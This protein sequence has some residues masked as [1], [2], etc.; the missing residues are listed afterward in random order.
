MPNLAAFTMKQKG[1]EKRIKKEYYEFLEKKRKNAK[2]D[3]QG[4]QKA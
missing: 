3:S 1:R 4:T 2:W